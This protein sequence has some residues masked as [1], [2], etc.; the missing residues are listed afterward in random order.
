MAKIL[1]PFKCLTIFPA[2]MADQILLLTEGIKPCSSILAFNSV[3]ITA[4]Y[5]GPFSN[6]MVQRSDL[7]YSPNELM[8]WPDEDNTER[9]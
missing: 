9:Q 4:K 7:R 6:K 3:R 1:S 8:V 5:S 2:C